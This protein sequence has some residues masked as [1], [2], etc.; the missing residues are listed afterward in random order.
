MFASVRHPLTIALLGLALGC[1]R[2]VP[3][4]PAPASPDQG[5][6]GAPIQTDRAEYAVRYTQQLAEL[7]IG[8]KYVNRTGGTVYLPTCQVPHPPVLEKRVGT[9][10][11]AAYRAPVLMCLGPPVVIRPGERYDYTFKVSAGRPGTNYFPQFEVAEITGTYRLVWG[12]LGTWDPDGSG[13]G[14]GR[15]LPL[16]QRVSNEFRITG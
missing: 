6:E 8:V 9:G 4:E 5:A 14:L 15:P 3:G 10:W 12:L 16:E 11:V 1:S 2:G 13:P 7:T